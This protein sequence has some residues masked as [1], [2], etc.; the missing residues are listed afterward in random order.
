MC[1]NSIVSFIQ[2]TI[3]MSPWFLMKINQKIVLYNMILQTAEFDKEMS[4]G[5][6]EAIKRG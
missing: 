1:A 4:N 6:I 3:T 5:I 2:T